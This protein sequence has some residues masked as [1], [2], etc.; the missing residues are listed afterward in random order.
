MMAQVRRI[1][2]GQTRTHTRIAGVQV[3]PSKLALWFAVGLLVSLGG[4]AYTKR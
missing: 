1:Q 4:W 2:L 3:E